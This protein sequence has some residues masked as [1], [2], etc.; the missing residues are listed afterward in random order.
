VLRM[1]TVV[2]LVAGMVALNTISYAFG[3]TRL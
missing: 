1:E 2:T 3:D